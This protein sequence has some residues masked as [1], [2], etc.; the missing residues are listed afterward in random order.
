M[1][2]N[3]SIYSF[4]PQF[5]KLLVPARDRL[6]RHG[7]TAN[8]ITVFTCCMCVAYALALALA[9]PVGRQWLLALLPL[10]LL[11][12][13]ILNALDGMVASH[14]GSHTALGSVLNEIGDVIADMALFAAFI[15]LAPH[16]HHALIVLVA[17]SFLIEFLSLAIHQ[18]MKVR[19]QEGPFGKSDRAF[20][21]GVLAL[22]LLL[23]PSH[24]AL[25]IAWTGVGI[26]LGLMTLRNRFRR[27]R[28]A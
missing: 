2:L 1:F 11:L 16:L 28:K 6:V 25:H 7:V 18:A 24:T 13:M 26:V 4:K 23:A 12:R 3:V 27:I 14:N 21:L 17:I 19:P 9:A 10:V 8:Q 22:L 15:V 20:F 5:Q